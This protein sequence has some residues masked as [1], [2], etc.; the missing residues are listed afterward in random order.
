MT[1]R[2]FGDFLLEVELRPETAGNSGIQVRSHVND[3]GR[4]YGYQVEID[5]SERAWSGG[6]YDEGRRAWLD[7]LSDNEAAR[8]AFR[9][10]EWNHYRIECLGPWIRTWVN[11]V[12]AADWLDPLDLEGF[13]GLQ[14]HAGQDT[15]VRWRNFRLRD[16]GTRSWERLEGERLAAV[17]SEHDMREEGPGFALD[18]EFLYELSLERGVLGYRLRLDPKGAT[19]RAPGP[20]ELGLSSGDLTT[21]YHIGKIWEAEGGSTYSLQVLCHADRIVLT[22]GGG[23]ALDPALMRDHGP[24]GARVTISHGGNLRLETLERLGEATR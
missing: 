8:K 15:R 1:E 17:W 24:W 18:T 16:L 22:S 10:G 11:G 4:V 21:G 19:A 23:L 9:P 3:K 13:I 20:I 7:D 2:S 6:L 12:P 5:S 14:V